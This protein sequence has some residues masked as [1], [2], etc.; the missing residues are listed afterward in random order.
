VQGRPPAVTRDRGCRTT[1]RGT[2]RAF[3]VVDTGGWEPRDASRHGRRRIAA[4]GGDL[5]PRASADGRAVSSVDAHGSAIT[6]TD[7]GRPCGSLRRLPGQA[8]RARRQQGRRRSRAEAEAHTRWLW[9][10]GARSARSRSRRCTAGGSGGHARRPCWPRLPE[11]SGRR[12]PTARVGGPRRGSRIVGPPQ[13]PASRRACS[14]SSPSKEAGRRRRRR[15]H[16]RRFRSTSWVE[17]GGPGTWAVHRHRRSED[18]RV[19]EGVGARV[20]REASRTKPPRSSV[21]R[22]C[23]GG[24]STGLG[25]RSRT[26]HPAACPPSAEAGSCPS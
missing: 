25:S 18:V 10:L 12:R 20:L 16:H 21:P 2:G 3:T 7:E 1:R 9:N 23:V 4:P 19:K 26:G 24:G 5:R 14:T 8:R 13:R 22:C 17:L 15:R 11:P 6:D